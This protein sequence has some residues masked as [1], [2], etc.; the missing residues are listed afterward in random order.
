MLDD[1]ATR[2]SGAARSPGPSSPSAAHGP[3]FPPRPARRPSGPDVAGALPSITL[4]K[5]GGA[6]RGLD[7]SFSVG[8]ATGAA[9]MAVPIATPPGRSGFGPSLAL[10]Y[11]TGA[12]NGPF[13]LGW[14]L[15]QPSVTRKTSKG[16]PR[17][18]D[19]IDSDVFL[20]SGSDELV[21]MREPDGHG[22][23]AEVSGPDPSG[24]FTVHRYRPRDES[25]FARIE[26]W[27]EIATGDVH[28][29]ATSADN[30]TSV[31]GDDDASRVRDPA[32]DQHVF[33]WLLARTYDA[34]GNVLA[35]EYKA[36][37][38]SN[39]PDVAHEQRRSVTANRYLKRVLYANV[40]PYLPASDP[41]LPDA[42][43]FEVVFDY[44]EHDAADPTP[45]ES[46]PWPCRPDPFS[47]YRSGFEIR[48]YRRCQ[49]IL[50][51]HRFPD[52]LA[53]DA[54]LVRST[55]LT[56]STDDA[57][58]PSLP[59]I[60]LLASVT[61]RGYRLDGHG[62]YQSRALPP[63]DLGYSKVAVHDAV[64]TASRE[65]VAE[66]PVGVDGR[67]WR[68]TDLDGDGLPGVLSEDDAAWYYH[69][70]LS[71]FDPDGGGP[72]ARFEPVALVASKPVLA[73]AGQP[74][75]LLD[76]HGDGVLCA[77]DFTP[78]AAG[79]HA[80]DGRGW[81]PFVPLTAAANLDLADP[82][83][84]HVDVDGDG[85][86]DLL[87]TD[88]GAFSW[89][90]WLEADEIGS[91]DRVTN[92]REE[93]DGPAV[94][95][96][97]GVGSILVADMSGDGL[98]DLVRVRNG[99][100]CYWPNLG[101]ARFGP[102]V[103]M[104]GAPW[105][106]SSDQFDPR[107][108]R[109]ADIDGSGT[110][111]L[112]YLGA[113]ATTLWFNQSGN[114]WS[115]PTVLSQL[116]AIDDTSAVAT[117]DLLGTGTSC[118]VWSSPL[119]SD[120]G[121]Q[122]RYIDLMGGTKPH[123]LT[124]IV[125]NTGAE[126]TITYSTS[127]RYRVEDHLSGI[128]WLTPLAFPV[129]V[130]AQVEVVDRVAGTRT[131][132]AYRYRHG[133]FDP[134]DREF[135]GFA[136]VEQTDT[137]A[138]PAASGIGTFSEVPPVVGDDF[139]LP[140]VLTRT[141]FHTGTYVD[142]V[143]LADVLGGE[144]WSGDPAAAR[145]GGALF[146]GMAS[147]EDGREGCRALRGH[148]LRT[149]LFVD[150]GTPD[151]VPYLTSDHRYEVRRLQPGS[152][153]SPGSALAYEVESITHHYE[154]DPTDPRLT[155][156]LALEVDPYGT[157]VRSA[158]VSYPRRVPTFTE[159][160]ATMVTYDEH[161]VVD[162]VDQDSWYR[163]AVPVESRTYELTGLSPAL[164]HLLFDPVLLAASSA[165][166]ATIA[167]DVQPDGT[168]QK[169]LLSCSR[170]VY[171]ADDLSGPL[172]VGTVES[173]ALVHQSHSLVMTK[174]LVTGVL[175][176]VISQAD[177]HALATSAIAALVDLDGDGNW[178]Q[179]S[180]RSFY[181]PD[182]V[183]PDAAFARTHFY[184]AQGSIDVFGSIETVTRELR[185]GDGR[186]DR[187]GRQ[188]DRSQGQLPRDGAMARDRRQRQPQRGA[189]R[190]AGPGRGGGDDGQAAPRRHRRGRS[191]RPHHRRAVTVRRSEQHPRLRPR[192]VPA[193][194]D[195]SQPRS[196]PPA[197]HL[198]AHPP[199]RSPQGSGHS[200]ARDLRVC[201][202]FWPGGAHQGASGAGR[203]ARPRARRRAPASQGRFARVRPR[204]DALGRFG[205]CGLR[206]QG[207]RGEELRAL[208]RQQPY[209]RRRIRP[210]GVGRHVDRPLRP[211]GSPHPQ[212]QPRR[213][214]P[215]GGLRSMAA[216]RQR[217]GGRRA[218]ERLVRRPH[219]RAARRR[220]AG[221]GHQGGGPRRDSSGVRPRLGREGVPHAGR[222]P[223]GRVRD[224]VGARHHRPGTARRSMPWGARCR[225][226]TTTWA[227]RR[228]TR[229]AST[230]AS[231][232][233]SPMLPASPCRPGTAGA[234]AFATPSM[235]STGHWTRT[236]RT[237]G[238]P[239]GWPSR[240]STARGRST[241]S[242]ATCEARRGRVATEPAS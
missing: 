62:T 34:F 167:Y 208:L 81:S 115:A 105:F 103:V 78:G 41:A 175:A 64:L 19:A 200:M 31:Y 2:G 83:L 206:Q 108:L 58:D 87:L 236:C 98:A 54:V 134:V 63:V 147:A 14:H 10:S 127:T 91:A 222:R 155:H 232:G 170:S 172:P 101:F 9:A 242:P 221:R 45:D 50:V 195:R 16:L 231:T 151:P 30:V 240:S 174:G 144:F 75:E 99:E 214:L 116:P 128:E 32:D 169:R 202:R 69:R 11:G 184:L 238:E 79:Y 17:Y 225:R 162:V 154:Q 97:D 212:G 150:D 1:P 132:S 68:W 139:T 153:T 186:I 4:P 24:D 6:V 201:R 233:R 196:R 194:G 65:A 56:Y 27:L 20:L 61:G 152:D 161:D 142:G 159:Q 217:R 102:K 228:C 40:G 95:F 53:R 182:P 100:V 180:A 203:R 74:T 211:A 29:R 141:W 216:Q 7:E 33:S 57:L 22:G 89:Y 199:S 177:A 42:W 189:L 109:F 77:V 44:G 13:G 158:D 129:H 178:W 104:D 66:L 198:V 190:R 39:V 160:G 234:S 123:L 219:G 67:R 51:F 85:L 226:R 191:P 229:R 223:N 21:P 207:Q 209:L 179:P 218:D 113:S 130:V 84:R 135:R 133:F 145:I 72:A 149:E 220:P 35:C 122:L 38:A 112:I 126:S 48:T 46:V 36:E 157:V 143:D 70:N 239:S 193:L 171:L 156:T 37:D 86:S 5:G 82:N 117:V 107:R 94:V 213:H 124:S 43:H 173:L 93:D 181:S 176:P 111:D 96:A 187:R 215:L 80:R 166:A 76:L 237:A 131:A 12:G 146:D 71:A 164:G 168:P 227:A 28:W 73:P 148:V 138:I 192:R 125:N 165:T 210:G 52:E 136:L 121:R 25:G 15:S 90:P 205:S 8:A 241:T 183:H 88:D 114:S 26:R 120:L 118:L 18:E 49:R 185:P 163:L 92:P 119:P 140:P 224:P 188:H 59:V 204:R 55:D 137:D 197:A 3:Q 60:S 106:E 23:W 47:S 230:A 235:R 110:S